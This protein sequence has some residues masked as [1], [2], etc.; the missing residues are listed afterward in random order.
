VQ[1]SAAQKPSVTSLP[2]SFRQRRPAW[3]REEGVV[4]A[5]VNWESLLR[6]GLSCRRSSAL[7]RSLSTKLASSAGLRGGRS[8][9]IGPIFVKAMGGGK[10][11]AWFEVLFEEPAGTGLTGPTAAPPFHHT[12]ALCGARQ[13]GA[14]GS[15]TRC[16]QRARKGQGDR[17]RVAHR[18][19]YERHVAGCRTALSR[20]TSVLCTRTLRP[21]H[22]CHG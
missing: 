7:C 12:N 17:K 20:F 2:K 18:G 1:S 10:P 9:N 13:I 19:E 3:W 21:C 4:M 15:S 8:V 16:R 22:R 11:S 6:R 5:G 14:S